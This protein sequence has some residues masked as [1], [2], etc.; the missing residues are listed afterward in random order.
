MRDLTEADKAAILE[1][2]D[3][4]GPEHWAE[5]KRKLAA[6]EERFIVHQKSLSVSDAK[7]KERFDI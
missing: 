7:L 1:R 6:M 4:L 5:V 2:I 3:N